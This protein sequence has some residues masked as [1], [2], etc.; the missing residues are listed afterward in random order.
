MAQR[1]GIPPWHMWGNSQ[2]IE[3]TIQDTLTRRT[4][5]PGQLVRINYAR[6]ETWHWLLAAKMLQGPDAPPAPAPDEHLQVSVAFDLTV[7]VGRAAITI[8]N[9]GAIF[10]GDKTF[11]TFL[12]EWGDGPARL[13]PVLANLWST[14]VLGPNRSFRSNAPFPNQEGFPTPG[15]FITGP[16]IIDQIVAQD[17][18]MS[19]RVIAL[20]TTPASP[21]I[22]QT[23]KV[24]VSAIFA[25]Q[26][27]V[28]P[29][30][31]KGGS[32]PGAEDGGGT[33]TVAQQVQALNYPGTP[34]RRT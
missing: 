20:D 5:T 30:W 32:F 22:G 24:E 13:F 2:I 23:V 6:P 3:T 14:Q 28:R 25:P 34:I 29:E 16:T 21:L 27:H 7:G 17:I 4:A 11:E 15:D 10:Q 19:C 33:G 9:A 18:Q 31:F 12:F 8:D 26:T 1:S